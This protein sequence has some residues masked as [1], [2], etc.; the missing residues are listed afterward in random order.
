MLSKLINKIIGDSNAKE[1]KRLGVI[2]SQINSLEKGLVSLSNEELQDKTSEFRERLKNGATV[3]ELLPEAFA[4][5]KNACRRLVGT[6]WEIR[7][8]PVQWEMIPYDVQLLGG[9]AIHEGKIAEMKTGEGKTL[10]CTLPLYLN[11][12]A[13]KGAHLVT[14]NNYLARRDAE[15]MG[16]LFKFLGMTVGVLDHGIPT[17]ERKAAYRCDITYGT[18]TE[19]GFDYL[20]DNMARSAEELMQ[21][22]LHYA[23]VDEVDS[24]LID[25]AR[26]PLIISAPAEESTSKYLRYSQLIRNLERDKHYELDEKAKT[27]TLTE[28]GITKMEGLL[29]LQNIYTEAGFS[30]VHHIEAALKASAVFTRDKDYVVKDG[31]ILIVDEFTGR[32]MPGRRYSEGLHQALEAKENVEVRRESKTLATITLQNYFRL[33]SKLAGMTGTALTEAEEFAKIYNLECLAVPTNREVTRHD[34]PDSVYKSEAG[35]FQAT[36]G[37]I[38]ELHEKGQPVLVGTIT[39]EKSEFLSQQLLRNGVPHK[40]LNAKHH[41]KEAEI[42]SKAGERAAVTIATNMAGRGTDIKLGDG[43][44]ELDGLFILGTERHE[45]RRIDNQLRG[46]SGRQG[47]PGASQFFVSMEDSLMR[48]FGG[49]KMQRM[50]DVLKVPE[51]MPIENGMISRSIES[52]QKKVEAHHF[53]IRKHLVEYD[54]VMNKQREIIY[55]RRRKILKHENIK[56]E[57]QKI[58]EDEARAIADGFSANR[59]QEDWDLAEIEKQLGGIFENAPTMEQL[60]EFLKQPELADFAAAEI[61]KAYQKREE[62]LPNR[63]ALRFAERQIYLSTIDRLW[64]E[65]LENMRHLREKVSLRGFG[66]R[67]PLVEYKNE[68]YI[69][70]EELLGNIRGNTIRALFKLKIEAAAPPSPSLQTEIPTKI[71]TNEDSVEDILTGDRELSPEQTKDVAAAAAKFLKPDPKIQNLGSSGVVKIRA[72]DSQSSTPQKTDNPIIVRAAKNEA[73]GELK[74]VGRNDPCPCGSGKK[75]KKCCGGNS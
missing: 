36:V 20:R 16:G 29:G 18:N 11:A 32:L 62:K 69:S 2:V 60:G 4:V 35:K 58:L 42:I 39:I 6:S 49:E 8:N 28:A 64:M 71:V 37:K 51:D 31:E 30:E 10:V 24:I 67:D 33:Y 15:W 17:D 53:D 73:S 46:R 65:H 63:E 56:D 3:D 68:A 48:L 21:R 13:G 54:D 9:I 25:E 5:V 26:T 7:G 23:I 40:V 59:K 38:K 66:Q 45:S 55:G 14:V 44:N 34:L 61:K 47:D 27:A 43:V 22:D 70:F 74:S 57:I 19:F 72:D 12:L 52:A 50:M 1:I 41:E 75:F